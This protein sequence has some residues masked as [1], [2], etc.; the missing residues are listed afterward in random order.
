MAERRSNYFLQF[1]EGQTDISKI[2]TASGEGGE[3]AVH[4][5]PPVAQNGPEISGI[6]KAWVGGG[7]GAVQLLP[8]TPSRP[9]VSKVLTARGGAGAVHLL[10]PAA[11][12]G[13][14]V[15]G[16]RIAMGGAVGEG[17]STYFL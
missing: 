2:L 17:R 5:L 11:Q 13:L 1:Q 3:E 9:D 7:R 8:A 14:D 12:N 16:A 10:P 4:L 15:S 6:R